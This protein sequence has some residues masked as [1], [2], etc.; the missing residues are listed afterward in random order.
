MYC[1]SVSRSGP[2]TAA[3]DSTSGATTMR[4]LSI[5]MIVFLVLGVGDRFMFFTWSERKLIIVNVE[6][7][8]ILIMKILLHY[9]CHMTPPSSLRGLLRTPR[10]GGMVGR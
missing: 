3:V 5:D 8:E 10:R 7:Y 6:D 1:A 2:A 4:A 9:R